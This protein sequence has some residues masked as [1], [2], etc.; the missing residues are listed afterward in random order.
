MH[1]PVTF[2]SKKG[3]R[4]W[5]EIGLHAKQEHFR[6]DFHDTSGTSLAHCF[7]YPFPAKPGARMHNGMGA[8]GELVIKTWPCIP[9]RLGPPRGLGFLGGKSLSG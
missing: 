9:S 8:V 7:T 5:W 4:P 2:T 3:F 1:D 6:Y